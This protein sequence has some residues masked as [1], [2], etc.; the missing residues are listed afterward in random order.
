[1]AARTRSFGAGA[2]PAWIL[3]IFPVPR[4]LQRAEVIHGPLTPLEFHRTI[5]QRKYRPLYSAGRK[6]KPGTKGS[7][8][9]LVQ[10]IM[11]LK[12]RDRGFCCPRI[13]QQINNESLRVP[14]TIT[15]HAAS[16]LRSAV[17]LPLQQRV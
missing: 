6:E 2:L 17:P 16:I 5:K 4:R 13:A 15:I 11:E 3:V 8:P 7:S 10:A 12:R 9:V 14:D 1:M